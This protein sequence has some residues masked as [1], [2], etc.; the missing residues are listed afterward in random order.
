MNLIEAIQQRRLVHWSDQGVIRTVE[1]HLFAQ[2]PGARL[3]VVAFE[4]VQKRERASDGYWKVIDIGDGLNIDLAKTFAAPRP[5]PLHLMYLAQLT[6]ANSSE[7][8]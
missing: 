8:R 7:N 6:Y 1:P 5:I 4:I 2:F 3:V